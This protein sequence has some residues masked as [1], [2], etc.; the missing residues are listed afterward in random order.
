[1]LGSGCGGDT[2]EA[3]AKI[4]ETCHGALLNE[5][6]TSLSEESCIRKMDAL[7]RSDASRAE[8]LFQCLADTACDGLAG[9]F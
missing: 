6:G 2:D 3:C 4:Y 9:C 1:G 5:D 8:S 7:S